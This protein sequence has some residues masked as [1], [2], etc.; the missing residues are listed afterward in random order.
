MTDFLAQ[1]LEQ[2]EEEERELER[3]F[4]PPEIGSH[5]VLAEPAVPEESGGGEG[6]ERGAFRVGRSRAQPPL[7]EREWAGT[8]GRALKNAVD[9]LPQGKSGEVPSPGGE[10]AVGGDGLWGG[11]RPESAG[12]RIWPWS[13]ER[14]SFR[15][16]GNGTLAEAVFR[17]ERVARFVQNPGRRLTVTLPEERAAGGETLTAEALDRAVERDARRYDGGFSLY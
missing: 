10:R 2:E 3:S 12:G 16:E 13:A 11:S 8:V 7:P 5:R 9:V 17:A 1:A 4:F 15:E 6:E 14:D